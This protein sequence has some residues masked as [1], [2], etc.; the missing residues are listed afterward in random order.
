MKTE[1]QKLYA[2]LERKGATS[3]MN[4]TKWGKAVQSLKALP[5]SYRVKYI[6]VDRASDWTWLIYTPPRYIEIGSWAGISTFLEIEWLEVDT[7]EKKHRGHLLDDEQI[8]H[9]GKVEEI[10]SALRVPFSKEQ[11]IIRIWGHL[12]RTD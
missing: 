12:L 7:I 1:K 10:L 5:L 9:T 4:N 8:I 6:T 11:A 3:L 2:L